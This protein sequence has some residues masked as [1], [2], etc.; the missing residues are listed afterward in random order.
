MTPRESLIAARKEAGLSRSALAALIGVNR[1]HVHHVE[2]G[3]RNPSVALMRRWA[4]A[5][6]PNSPI[7][8]DE[9]IERMSLQLKPVATKTRRAA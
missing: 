2:T 9:D 8:T 5:L 1:S 4:I 6:K 7:W 3:I